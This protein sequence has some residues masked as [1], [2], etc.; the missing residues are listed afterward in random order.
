V[1]NCLGFAFCK[2]IFFSLIITINLIFFFFFFFG[3]IFWF[4]IRFQIGYEN[5]ILFIRKFRLACSFMVC[6]NGGR[7]EGSIGKEIRMV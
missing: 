6:L 5:V 2:F 4:G 1:S 7:V 3:F